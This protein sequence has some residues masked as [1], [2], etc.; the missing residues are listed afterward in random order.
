M[1]S[2]LVLQSLWSLEN[3]PWA[4]L[5]AGLEATIRQVAAAGFDGVGVNLARRGRA[6]TTARVCADLGQTW[7]AQAYVRSAD[8]L[9]RFIDQAE[10]LGGAHHLNVQVGVREPRLEPALALM[11][12]LEA[13]A[14]QA[15]LPVFYETHRGRLTNDLAFTVAL[16]EACPGVRLTGDLSHYVV[17]HEMPLPI[18]PAESAAIS[19]VLDRC[20]S[21]HGR[22][23]DTNQVQVALSGPRQRP[24]VDQFA[25]WWKDGFRRWRSRS[26]TDASLTFLCELGPPSYA[27]TDPSGAE[28]S[29]RW[30]EALELKAMARALFE[31]ARSPRTAD[32]PSP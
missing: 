16:L 3:I 9:S 4:D 25:A 31:A 29:D 8:E 11:Q 14:A 2:L 28:L 6:E 15:P 23:A 19:Q 27:I 21:F 10:A 18:P 20:E 26:P 12:S 32:A 13:V 7:E 22:V 24:W 1:T 17:A 30:L 5:D